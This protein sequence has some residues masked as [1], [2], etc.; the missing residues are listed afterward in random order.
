[1]HTTNSLSKGRHLAFMHSKH[2]RFRQH[3]YSTHTLYINTQFPYHSI[4]SSSPSP[5]VAEVLKMAHVLLLSAARPRAVDTSE[6]LIAPSRSC[7]LA[8]THRMAVFSSSSCR[9]DGEGER[10][11]DGEQRSG[12]KRFEYTICSMYVHMHT[13]TDTERHKQKH[14]CMHACTH[15]QHGVQLR[16]GY[17][18]PIP[19]CT[20]H[21]IN[22]CICVGIVAPPVR[23]AT[24]RDTNKM[25]PPTSYT[26]R[27][28]PM[29]NLWQKSQI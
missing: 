16:L 24:R 18:H 9:G 8:N 12:G 17:P 13:H 23:P 20:V 14:V 15:L 1:M 11:R 10:K 2:N 26:H 5:F 27:L 22:H 6:G 28:P 21:H 3:P 29:Y 4:A 19:V 7:L 25:L